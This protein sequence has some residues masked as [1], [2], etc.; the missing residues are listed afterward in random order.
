MRS[1]ARWSVSRARPV[2]VRAQHEMS[3]DRHGAFGGRTT[4]YLAGAM[5]QSADGPAHAGRLLMRSSPGVSRRVPAPRC[6][7]RDFTRSV[8]V[9]V[10][11]LGTRTY[12]PDEVGAIALLGRQTGAREVPAPSTTQV[13]S[14]RSLISRWLRGGDFGPWAWDNSRCYTKRVLRNVAQTQIITWPLLRSEGQR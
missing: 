5:Q 1:S 9:S 12:S 14:G 8:N 4:W 11:V 6:F 10:M 2:V 13:C 7:P 3:S